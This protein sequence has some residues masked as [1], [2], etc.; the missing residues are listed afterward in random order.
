[1]KGGTIRGNVNN[2]QNVVACGGG[3]YIAGFGI[4]TM[5]GGTIAGNTAYRSGGGFHTGSRGSF[6][7]SGGVIYGN[8]APEGLQN[9]VINGTGDPVVYGYAVCVALL[10]PPLF[11]YRDD[12]VTEAA[13]LSYVGSAIGNGVF[14]EGETW[15]VPR[16]VPSPFVIFGIP[17]AV[18]IFLLRKRLFKG[19][20]ADRRAWAS[21]GEGSRA[22]TGSAV[23]AEPV[24][25]EPAASMKLSPREKEVYAL[26]L[27]NLTL[28]QIALQLRI[29]YH[30]VNNHYRNIYKKLGVTSKGELFMKS[31]K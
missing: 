13:N 3:V 18:L 20:T 2:T 7:K 6:K 25:L 24:G 19:G 9:M 17:A 16:R 15:S 11:R 22:E 23:D 14:G 4:F 28:R 30:T 26:L 10:D 12:T 29:S 5:E 31:V 8:D 27:K 1:M 21:G